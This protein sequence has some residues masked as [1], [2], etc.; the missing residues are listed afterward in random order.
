MK[1]GERLLPLGAYLI[2]LNIF[3]FFLSFKWWNTLFLNIFN[4][5]RYECWEGGVNKFNFV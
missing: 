4:A 1:W 3:L 5:P 2:S